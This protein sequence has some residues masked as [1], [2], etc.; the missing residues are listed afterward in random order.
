MYSISH[1][2][3]SSWFL[4]TMIRAGCPSFASCL[5]CCS[6]PFQRVTS[7]GLVS[8]QFVFYFLRQQC[9]H[10]SSIL[11]QEA[12]PSQSQKRKL[13]S[14]VVTHFCITKCVIQSIIGMTANAWILVHLCINYA[15]LIYLYMFNVTNRT[16]KTIRKLLCLGKKEIIYFCF[17]WQFFAFCF[18]LFF[19]TILK[20]FKVGADVYLILGSVTH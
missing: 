7:E 11:Y 13:L 17:L 15:I 14:E 19:L 16:T 3:F 12:S 6:I 4:A 20:M 8:S 1:G 9:S 18:V 2:N 5:R 10:I